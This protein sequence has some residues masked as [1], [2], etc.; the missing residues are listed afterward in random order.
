[1]HSM[2]EISKAA[3]ILYEDIAAFAER[4]RELDMNIAIELD[5]C[6]RMMARMAADLKEIKA[7]IGGY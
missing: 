7:Y 3:D 5:K 1:M 6:A 4:D 2:I